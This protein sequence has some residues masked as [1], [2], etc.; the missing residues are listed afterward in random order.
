MSGTETD[1]NG[2]LPD[3][4]MALYALAAGYCSAVDRESLTDLLAVFTE[5][6]ELSVHYE[7]PERPDAVFRGHAELERVID[8]IGRYDKTFHFLG[9]S[10]F[11]ND[12]GIARGEVYCKAHHLMQ[13]QVGGVDFVM[14][15]RYSDQYSKAGPHWRIEKRRLDVDWT[16]TRAANRPEWRRLQ[17]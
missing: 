2:L 4:Q 15:I 13:T 16:E 14:F 6:A 5:D 7:H 8:G 3:D 17:K 10:R 12:S 11:W 1:I 9:G